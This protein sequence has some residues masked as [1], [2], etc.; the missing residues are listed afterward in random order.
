MRYIVVVLLL[1]A[2]CEEITTPEGCPVMSGEFGQAYTRKCQQIYYEEQA[3]ASGGTVTRCF[4][5]PGAMTC[6][7]D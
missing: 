6:I 7:S 5:E 3:R 1:L 2:G 4:G